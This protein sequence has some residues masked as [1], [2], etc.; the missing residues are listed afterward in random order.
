MTKSQPNPEF[1]LSDSNAKRLIDG[2][3][4]DTG[5]STYLMMVNHLEAGYNMVSVGSQ[6]RLL[7][8][9]L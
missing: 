7:E 9:R 2:T 6:F 4:A 8:Q 5:Y 1:K 3:L